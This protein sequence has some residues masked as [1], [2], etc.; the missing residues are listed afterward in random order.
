M[1]FLEISGEDSDYGAMEIIDNYS[2][3]KLE[4]MFNQA[5]TQPE[6][7]LYFEDEDI[8]ELVTLTAHELNIDNHAFSTLMDIW[9][10]YDSQKAHDIIPIGN[11]E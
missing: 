3:E 1:K 8:Q 4:D 6:H 9:G 11:W 7:T 5:M 10:D 2:T